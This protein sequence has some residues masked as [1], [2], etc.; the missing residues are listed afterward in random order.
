MS[1]HHTPGSKEYTVELGSMSDNWVPRGSI[2]EGT[3]R[4]TT[5]TVAVVAEDE[6][7]ATPDEASR[8]KRRG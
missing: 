6:E 8:V 2:H 3:A 4:N 5:V 7:K 1:S